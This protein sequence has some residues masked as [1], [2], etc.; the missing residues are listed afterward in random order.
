MSILISIVIPVY[1]N[2]A[3]ISETLE[4]CLNQSIKEYEILLV[5][6]NAS[7]ETLATVHPF[8][9]QH[10]GKIRLVSE[11]RQGACSARNRGIIESHG[12]Y[13]ALL[14]D[15][16]MMYPRRLE[17]QLSAAEKHPEAALIHSLFDRVSPD[18][19]RIVNKAASSTPEFWRKLLFEPSSPLAN[20]PTVLPSVMF[21]RRETAIRAGLFDEQFNPECFEESEFCLRMSELGPFIRVDESLGRYRTH[22][23]TYRLARHKRLVYIILRNQDRF[24]RI[25]LARY[26][27]IQNSRVR[28]AFRIIRG[29]WLREASFLLFPYQSGRQFAK[30]LVHR[31]L[32]ENPFDL[33]T[34]KVWLK[35]W[36]P[37]SLWPYAFN[38]SEWIN[39]ALPENLNSEFLEGILKTDTS[40]P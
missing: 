30:N 16:D 32:C 8:V 22:P 12:E 6:N 19:R 4:S 14:D 11:S 7:T 31:S 20:E 5:N 17:L 29:Q 13:I 36:Y 3:I 26:G 21:F 27:S 37:L 25:L 1:K 15:D 39:E 33:K 38:F 35:T 9:V 2:N 23:E 10:P 40:L 24:Y 18:N 28:K 34:W